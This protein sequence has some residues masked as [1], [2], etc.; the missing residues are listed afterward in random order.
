MFNS[1]RCGEKDCIPRFINR[2]LDSYIYGM[3]TAALETQDKMKCCIS[4]NV[5]IVEGT[6]AFELLSS[7]YKT[8]VIGRS[9]THQTE[10]RHRK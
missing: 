2:C 5:V 4:M 6:F 7:V 1:L 9:A 3:I 10:I 8:L